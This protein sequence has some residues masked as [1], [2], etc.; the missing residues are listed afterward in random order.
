M[1]PSPGIEDELPIRLAN[2]GRVT[3]RRRAKRPRWRELRRRRAG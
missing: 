1:N 2:K 3:F